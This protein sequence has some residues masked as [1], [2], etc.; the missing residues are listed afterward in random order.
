MSMYTLDGKDLDDPRG[1]WVLE[2]GTTLSTWGEPRLSSVEV[3]N[4]FGVL[5][6]PATVTDAQQVV[7]KFR[8]FSWTD[9]GK[10]LCHGTQADLDA[11][12]RALR[13]RLLVLGR[14]PVLGHTPSGAGAAPR[15][16]EVRL[17]GSVEP[18]FSPDTMTIAVSAVFEIPDGMW[19]DP[20]P[21]VVPLASASSL[22]GGT[23]PIMDAMIM[24]A[25]TANEMVVK[26]ATSGSSLTWKGSTIPTSSERILVNV[27]RYTAHK[28]ASTG[29]DVISGAQD[30]SG[31]ISMSAG[32]LRITPDGD[33]KVGLVVTGGSGLI[34]AR[35][36]Y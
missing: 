16:A 12:L 32:G 18:S 17:K 25:P 33:G 2:E 8:V 22:S 30:V 14:L 23:A 11:N 35:R 4:R 29:W 21:T 10:S 13:N 1:R 15:V 24:L 7:L 26:D 28:Q 31:Q 20:E 19:R 27:S 5:P 34:R 3:P 36:A 9:G 6:I